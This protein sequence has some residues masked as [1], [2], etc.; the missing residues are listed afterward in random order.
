VAAQ[1]A[2][3]ANS[4]RNCADKIKRACA[5]AP[6]CTRRTLVLTTMTM[7]AR[8]ALAQE[9]EG[10]T[11]N[12][13]QAADNSA[14][15]QFWSNIAVRQR[16]PR[17]RAPELLRAGPKTQHDSSPPPHYDESG[18]IIARAGIRHHSRVPSRRR[19]QIAAL[20]VTDLRE[21]AKEATVSGKAEFDFVSA[22][23][24]TGQ[25]Q[26]ERSRPR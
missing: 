15:P 23:D 24:S 9:A 22:A 16:P 8:P 1:K 10:E 25:Q 3:T 26:A 21:H 2:S 12:R 20:C 17:P 4:E 7:I 13:S 6:S 19:T 5:P 14:R 18:P 11:A